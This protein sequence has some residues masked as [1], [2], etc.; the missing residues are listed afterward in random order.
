M[1]DDIAL[2]DVCSDMYIDKKICFEY[3]CILVATVIYNRT[4]AEN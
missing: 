1:P 4:E 3:L 2:I